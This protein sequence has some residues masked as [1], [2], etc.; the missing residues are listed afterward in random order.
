MTDAQDLLKATTHDGTFYFTEPPFNDWLAI[1]G[2]DGRGTMEVE[3]IFGRLVSLDGV[4][5]G[6]GNPYPDADALRADYK[7]RP[8]SFVLRTTRG[9]WKAWNA[10]M[11]DDI[12]EA[13]N[14]SAPSGT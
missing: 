2:K 7:N 9:F 11:H 14:E 4:K 5:D 3:E 10:K 6:A 13:K 12:D 8:S 1:Y